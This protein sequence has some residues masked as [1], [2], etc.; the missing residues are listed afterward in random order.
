MTTVTIIAITLALLAVLSLFGGVKSL[1]RGQT[2]QTVSQVTLAVSFLAFAGMFC[3]GALSLRGYIGF[4]HEQIVATITVEPAGADQFQ[5]HIIT[6]NGIQNSFLISGDQL[7]VDAAILK[8]KPIANIMGLHTSYELLRVYGRYLMLK[9]EQTKPHTVFGLQ[10]GAE[11]VDLFELQRRFSQFHYFYD[12]EYGS[13]SFVP[14]KEK[15]KFE[16]FIST[17][18]LLFRKA[19]KGEE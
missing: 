4:N 19:K 16:L 3:L 5:A 11:W 13:A 7:V 17:S 1:K 10:K 6:P 14:A 8:W 9:D 2:G 12:A 15:Q 18:G